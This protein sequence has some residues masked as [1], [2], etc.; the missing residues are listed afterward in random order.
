[1]NDKKEEYFVK[2]RAILEEIGR[3]DCDVETL[4]WIM[5]DYLELLGR[6]IGIVQSRP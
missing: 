6:A 2:C 3:G 4:A 5:E 1:M